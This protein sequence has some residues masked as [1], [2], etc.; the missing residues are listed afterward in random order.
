MSC[1]IFRQD[2]RKLGAFRKQFKTVPCTALTATATKDVRDDIIKSL[3]LGSTPAGLRK[4]KQSF[5]RNNLSLRVCAKPKGQDGFAC[6]VAY[7]RDIVKRQV[8]GSC[9]YL[10]QRC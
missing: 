6:L 2:Y 7:L 10:A 1:T 8:T 4:F 3:Q 5:F 9:M